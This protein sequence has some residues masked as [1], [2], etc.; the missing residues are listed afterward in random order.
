M[1][2][3]NSSLL[4]YFQKPDVLGPE[5]SNFNVYPRINKISTR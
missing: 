1:D 3:F 2:L 4:D 5:I